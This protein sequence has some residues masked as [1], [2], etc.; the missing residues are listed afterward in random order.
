LEILNRESG[1]L[2]NNFEAQE[3]PVG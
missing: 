3:V 2:N 1:P